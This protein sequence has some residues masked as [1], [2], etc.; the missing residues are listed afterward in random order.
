M[1][2]DA[3][4]SGP[5]HERI[6]RRR[7]ERGIPANVLA[8]RLAISPSYVS[9]IESGKKVPGEDIAR[10]IAEALNDDVEIYV[11]WA[12]SAGISDLDLH[13]DRLARLYH[14]S[15]DPVLQR[16][17]RSGEDMPESPLLPAGKRGALGSI[18]PRLLRSKPRAADESAAPTEPDLAV[19]PFLKE[20][21]DPA[22]SEKERR[23]AGPPLRLDA[24]LF[25][26]D[27][28]GR[29]FVYR[30]TPDMARRAGGSVRLGDWLILS[31]H[32]NVQDLEGLFA[33][34]TKSGVLLSRVL[35]KGNELLLLPPPGATDFEI[36]ELRGG[37]DLVR[38]LAGRVVMKI[39]G[40]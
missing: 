31:T 29:L 14:Y 2:R 17:L 32:V 7:E 23:V 5:M 30:A 12:H 21:A 19:I 18:I 33:I 10:R 24:R 25:P 35:V 26:N 22:A 11:A 36:V 9:L 34:R 28:L 40:L 6:R 39:R 37:A 3:S 16:Q 38:V 20:G 15:S 8:Q 27:E 1:G 13:T 4:T